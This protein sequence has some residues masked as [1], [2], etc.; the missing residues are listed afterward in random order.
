MHALISSTSRALAAAVLALGLSAAAF[1]Q[2]GAQL[3]L[4]SLDA[5]EGRAEKVVDVTLDESLLGMVGNVINS[6]VG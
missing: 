5:L 1:A 6:K 3:R 2:Q 4:D